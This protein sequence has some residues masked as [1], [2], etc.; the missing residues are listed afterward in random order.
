MSELFI[1]SFLLLAHRTQSRPTR[2]SNLT[3]AQDMPTNLV[4][5][6]KEILLDMPPNLVKY[7][8]EILFDMPTNL[9][10]YFK[11]ILLDMPTNL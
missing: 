4:K 11:E 9:E 10:K 1:K 3:A 6:L 7:F 8:K 5:Y 2:N